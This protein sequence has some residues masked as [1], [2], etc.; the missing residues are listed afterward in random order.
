[1]FKVCFSACFAREV[2]HCSLTCTCVTGQ[3]P[4]RICQ[5]TT[6]FG[7]G[8]KIYIYS[9]I[10]SMFCTAS[11]PCT[12]LHKG[13]EPL[14]VNEQLE[15]DVKKCVVCNPLLG[16]CSMPNYFSACFAERSALTV[17]PRGK[18]RKEVICPDTPGLCALGQ[19]LFTTESH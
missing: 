4:D 11:P 3:I 8:S 18:L 2:S 6:L 16:Q 13:K 9:N 12:F 1:M 14:L 10:L 7:L 5:R 17:L 19:K 15:L